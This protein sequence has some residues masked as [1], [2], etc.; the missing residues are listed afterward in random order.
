TLEELLENSAK[1]VALYADHLQQQWW[2]LQRYPDLLPCFTQ[3]VMQSSPV[4]CEAE[5]GCQLSKM[6]LV[7][8]QGLQA[9][10][11]CELFRLFFRDRTQHLK[12]PGA[13]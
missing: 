9:S 5:Q 11:A 6:G 2:N 1:S 13:W 12:I 4:D 7:H 8:L 10:L 3:I